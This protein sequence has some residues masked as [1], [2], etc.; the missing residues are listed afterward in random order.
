MKTSFTI[1]IFVVVLAVIFSACSYRNTNG[2]ADDAADANAE[3]SSATY[4]LVAIEGHTPPD[5]GFY[6]LDDSTGRWCERPTA[7]DIM[8]YSKMSDLKNPEELPDLT[9]Y[10]SNEHTRLFNSCR[11]VIRDL[12]KSISLTLIYDGE[13]V[14]A[15]SV[16]KARISAEGNYE[17]RE[18]S[19]WRFDLP[20]PEGSLDFTDATDYVITYSANPG[21]SFANEFGEYFLKFRRLPD[22]GQ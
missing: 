21:L 10:F 8:A 3:G 16:D 19:I 12:G 9:N 2:S 22:G 15:A 4:Q 5:G 13:E 7:A 17:F 11:I 18:I 20:V 14:Y 1:H 6:E